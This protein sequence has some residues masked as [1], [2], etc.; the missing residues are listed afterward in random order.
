MHL[1][2]FVETDV[3]IKIRT[4]GNAE[5]SESDREEYMKGALRNNN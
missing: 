5:E 4:E 1:K 2:N 3:A